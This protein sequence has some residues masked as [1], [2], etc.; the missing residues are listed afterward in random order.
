MNHNKIGCV[1]K[2]NVKENEYSHFTFGGSDLYIERR[3]YTGFL[4]PH[5]RLL[6]FYSTYKRIM[7]MN[8][9]DINTVKDKALLLGIYI[10]LIDF[11][12]I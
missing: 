1:Q 7:G 8:S 11:N 3:W 12:C 6:Y 9:I 2:C 10:K 5:I 4:Y